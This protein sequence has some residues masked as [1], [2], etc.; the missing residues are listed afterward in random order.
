MAERVVL[1]FP[2]QGSHEEGMREV[3]ERHRPALLD[4]LR[5]AAG[6]D[7]FDRAEAS[8]A[9]AQPAIVCA[10]IAH[11]HAR[12]C[13]GADWVTGHSL[14]ELTALVAAGSLDE[15]DAVRL[16]A[17]RGELMQR[18][19]DEHPGCGMLAAR[20][21]IEEVEPVAEEC[22]VAV[23][24][25]NSPTQVVLS[26]SADGLDRARERLKAAGI[27]STR[28]R[29]AGAFHSPL[30]ASAVEPFRA[31]LEHVE[32]APPRS[33]VFSPISVAPMEDPR[34]A[35]PDSLLSPVRWVET[36]QALADEGAGRFEEV[37]PGGVLTRLIDATL[38]TV[39]DRA[40][41]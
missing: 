30:M 9:A 37:G 28:L 23:G 17:R 19:S 38:S 39:F 1:A 12:G 3:V 8:T 18:A 21:P 31:A 40:A 36:V 4:T 7:A 27:R 6:D 14:G 26:G 20:A 35:L 2:G 29:V 15:H 22:G 13:P 24:N 33:V 32:F 11:W 16:A 5:S 34:R 10:S 25:H 41:D